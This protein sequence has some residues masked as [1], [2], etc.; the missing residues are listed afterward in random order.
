MVENNQ[1]GIMK[2]SPEGRCFCTVLDQNIKNLGLVRYK[3][4]E[5]YSTKRLNDSRK[6]TCKGYGL[7]EKPKLLSCICNGDFMLFTTSQ[8]MI[9]IWKKVFKE[10]FN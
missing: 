5:Q 9:L 2:A 6:I 1:I 3:V 4:P 8:N 7:L 10:N